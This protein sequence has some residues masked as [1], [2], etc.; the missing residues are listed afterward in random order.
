M[1]LARFLK[2]HPGYVVDDPEGSSNQL[3]FPIGA[4][5]DKF[6]LGLVSGAEHCRPRR[7]T[8]PAPSHNSAACGFA[9]VPHQ[10][11]ERARL[12]PG[13]NRQRIRSVMM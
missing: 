5:E 9:N 8:T 4:L 1:L 10:T 2:V 7:R 13:R 3:I 12:S 11:A 6:D